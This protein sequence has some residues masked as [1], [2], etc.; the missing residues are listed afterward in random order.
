[1]I[2][3]LECASGASGDMLAAALCHLCR[4]AG[5]DGDGIVARALS[6]AGVDPAAAR[7][8]PVVRGGLAALA[9]EVDDVP[10]FDTFAELEAAV[11]RSSLATDV[12]RRV[13]A[14]ARRMAGAEAA[15]HGA[16]HEA[17]HELAGVDTIVDLVSVMALSEAL[18]ADTVIASP[19]AL[20]GGWIEGAHGRLPV[21]APAVLGLLH[22][23]PTAGGDG[24][25]VGELT[26]PTGAALLTE[27]AGSFGPW[28]AGR[29]VHSGVGAGSREIAGCANVLRASLID[30]AA[31]DGPGMVS[32]DRLIMLE[33]TVDD[34]SAEYLADAV[35]R[36]RSAGVRDVWLTPV[37]MKKGR[38]AVC[39]HALVEKDA[40]ERCVRSI[41]ENTTTF[42][43][44]RTSVDRLRLDERRETV[45]VHGRRVGVRLGLLDGRLLTVA[46]EYEDCRRVAEALGMPPRIVFEQA[47][48]AARVR[49]AVP[50]SVQSPGGPA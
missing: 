23:V 14:V 35:E 48:A 43:I 49:F 12:R 20:G 30:L 7:F 32:T 18:A 37:L 13:T 34:L 17:L 22:D 16:E 15:A 10:G 1:M 40:V 41:F 31:T 25:E 46:P 38:A 11:G 47:Q 29:I 26:T 50:D 45:P 3:Y 42:G 2:L 27:L 24:R 8:T 36:L 39:L 21:P 9:F 44:R 33:T 28:P 4:T 19:P 5:I 6:A